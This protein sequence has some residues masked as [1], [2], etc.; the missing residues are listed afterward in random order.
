MDRCAGPRRTPNCVDG[1]PRP[2]ASASNCV[3]Q[4]PFYAVLAFFKRIVANCFELSGQTE[5]VSNMV[6]R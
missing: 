4:G 5:T 2:L 6:A 3:E 1:R